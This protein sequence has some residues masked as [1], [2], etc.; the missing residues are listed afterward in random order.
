MWPEDQGGRIMTQGVFTLDE[1]CPSGLDRIKK[2]FGHFIRFVRGHLQLHRPIRPAVT[3]SA[4]KAFPLLGLK[5]R[6][7][8]STTSKPKPTSHYPSVSV[9]SNQLELPFVLDERLGERSFTHL[10]SPAV[11]ALDGVVY[12]SRKTQ[13]LGAK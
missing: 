5:E 4:L 1:V 12:N 13:R 3:I 2:S 10:V 7:A 6:K 9:L 8:R 11:E